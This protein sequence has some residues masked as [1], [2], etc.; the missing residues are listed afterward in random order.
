MFFSSRIRLKALAQLCHRLATATKAGIEDRKI[1]S[2]EAERGSRLQRQMISLISDQL[3][4]RKSL[5]ETLPATG[6]F[7]PPLF[8]QMVEVGE[9]SGRLDDTYKRLATHYD[10]TLK[11]RRDFMGQLSWP[12]IQL[13]ISLLVVGLLIWIMGMLPINR[14]TEGAQIDI[15]G[16]GLIGTSGLI[17]YVNI[18][19]GISIAG[20]IA[21][22]AAR[23]GVGWS[24]SLQRMAIRIPVLGGA[25]KTLALSRFTWALQLVLDTPMDLRRAMPLALDAS[26]NDYYAQHGY[27][28]ANRIENGQTIHASLAETGVFPVDLL[29]SVAVGEQSGQLVETMERLSAEYQQRATGA[30]SLLAQLA[31]YAIWLLVSAFIIGL[32]F[33]IFSF[34]TSQLNAA[35]TI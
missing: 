27:A 3:A 9:K 35:G 10:R 33:Q 20:L 30:I 5:S 22:E 21:V 11:G 24:R 31:G 23:R 29:D 32:I 18:L 6:K 14:G 15:L 13:G 16:V 1:W 25:L 8:R 19:V 12:L 26:G 7:F 28:V 34:Y 2:S 4:A 17:V